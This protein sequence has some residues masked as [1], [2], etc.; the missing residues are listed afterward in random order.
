[1]RV[2]A[3]QKQKIAHGDFNL[4]KGLLEK[5]LETVKSSLLTYKAENVGYDN[6]LRGRGTFIQELIDLLKN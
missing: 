3:D 2:S 1:M 4:L 6:V 5:E